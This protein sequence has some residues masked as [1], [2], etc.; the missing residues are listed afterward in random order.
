MRWLRSRHSRASHLHRWTKRKLDQRHLRAKNRAELRQDL[1]AWLALGAQRAQV[2]E[3]SAARGESWEQQAKL[4]SL[5]IDEA[6]HALNLKCYAHIQKNQL[7]RG[8]SPWLREAEL[9]S[10]PNEW[11]EYL[12]V[13]GVPK[14]IALRSVVSESLS[15]PLTAAFAAR[16]AGVTADPASGLLS[17]LVLG[18][19]MGA[20]LSGLEKWAELLGHG[21][22]LGHVRSLHILFCGPRVPAK[23]DGAT[24]TFRTARD[25]LFTAAF[26]RG[27]WHARADDILQPDS[28]LLPTEDDAID[29]EHG[30]ANIGLPQLCLAFNSGLAEHAASWLPSL[31]DLFWARRLPMAFTSYHQPEAELDAR[32]L[33]V[34][35]RVPGSMLE[36]MP[37]PFASQLPHLDEIFPGRTYVANAFLSVAVPAEP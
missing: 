12:D 11:K 30:R 7:Q 21:H 20:E 8:V 33:A 10:V 2:A 19:E 32:T 15:F 26:V 22:G 23:L 5:E 35:L 17:L 36:C 16:I 18:A 14:G 9:A 25:E 6:G 31:R 29:P 3:A 1:R 34:R 27:A 4:Q 24:R 37:N 13:A 28:G